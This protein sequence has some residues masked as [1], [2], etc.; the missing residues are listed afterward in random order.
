[1]EIIKRN[2]HLVQV[3]K[4]MIRQFGNI[5]VRTVQTVDGKLAMSVVDLSK[6]ISGSR[7]QLRQLVRR[8][9]HLLEGR[10]FKVRLSDVSDIRG[11]P[12]LMVLTVQGVIFIALRLNPSRVKD[13]ERRKNIA[14]LQDWAMQALDRL[15]PK[16]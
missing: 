15:P 10:A 1:M 3:G 8:H 11:R 16:L 6:L 2:D 12:D 4:M 9:R 14:D 5:E 13:P 7:Q